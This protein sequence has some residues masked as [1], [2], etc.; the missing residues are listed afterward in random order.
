[1]KN[2]LPHYWHHFSKSLLWLQNLV[3]NQEAMLEV[4]QVMYQCK[5]RTTATETS[6]DDIEIEGDIRQA[7]RSPALQDLQVYVLAVSRGY[8]AI[9]CYELDAI[10]RETGLD[11]VTLELTDELSDL[12]ALC[13]TFWEDIC[14][15]FDLSNTNQEFSAWVQMA[16]G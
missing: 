14:H 11:I 15:F 6:L 3:P 12:G 2:L 9:A 4:C 10:A 7:R 16:K 1:M 8:R 5:P 13:V